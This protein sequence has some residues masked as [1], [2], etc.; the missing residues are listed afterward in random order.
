VTLILQN[1]PAFYASQP[2]AAL[3][4]FH[5]LYILI[6]ATQDT[7]LQAETRR[8]PYDMRAAH[9]TLLKEK[10]DAEILVSVAQDYAALREAHPEIAACLLEALRHAR[11]YAEAAALAQ[12]E[13]T[14]QIERQ[15]QRNIA[16]SARVAARDIVTSPVEFE[17]YLNRMAGLD[18]AEQ[19][20]G[21]GLRQ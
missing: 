7:D 4:I 10:T 14:N 8:I 11:P 3:A 17:T 16:R 18:Q 9:G 6:H 12:K 2:A 21:G 13:I 1:L 19:Q 20:R 5:A 15:I